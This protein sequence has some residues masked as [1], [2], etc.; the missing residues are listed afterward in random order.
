[1]KPTYK[2]IQELVHPKRVMITLYARYDKH[3]K[4]YEHNRYKLGWLT[5]WDTMPGP[6]LWLKEYGW[7]EYGVVRRS[8][9]MEIVRA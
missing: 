6:G 7:L 9:V 1:M 2:I 4:Y 5:V 3:T 8:G